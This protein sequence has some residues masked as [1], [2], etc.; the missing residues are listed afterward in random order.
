M[1]KIIG[2]IKEENGFTLIEM[3]VVLLIIALLLLIIIPNIGGVQDS[4]GDTTDE[5]IVQT[6]ESQKVLYEID[7]GKKPTNLEEMVTKGYITPK[8]KEVYE[9]K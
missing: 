6:V 5:A 3:S 7:H 1:E 8:Q 4:V 2:K 9:K